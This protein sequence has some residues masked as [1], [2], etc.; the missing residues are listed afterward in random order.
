M[1]IYK[2]T[3]GIMEYQ[4]RNGKPL[5]PGQTIRIK[6]CVGPYGQCDTVTG[7]LVSINQYGGL[8]ITLDHD[9]YYTFKGFCYV[10][11]KGEDYYVAAPFELRNNVMVGYKEHKDFEH[12]HEAWVEIL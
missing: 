7:K 3:K 2:F 5:A 1:T 11:K 6:H 9:H 4:D 10:A 8:T 12:G